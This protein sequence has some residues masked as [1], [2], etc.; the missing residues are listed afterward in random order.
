MEYED[1]LKYELE[2]HDLF[3]ARTGVKGVAPRELLEE[4]RLF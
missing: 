1:F 4:I 2:M 3:I